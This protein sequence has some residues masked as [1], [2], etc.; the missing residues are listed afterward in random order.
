MIVVNERIIIVMFE[1][2][3]KVIPAIIRNIPKAILVT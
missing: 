1:K 3:A 2:C